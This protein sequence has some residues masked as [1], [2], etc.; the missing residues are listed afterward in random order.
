MLSR[1]GFLKSLGGSAVA[2]ALSSP[3]EVLT[4]CSSLKGATKEL[5]VQNGRD[6]YITQP[7]VAVPKELGNTLEKHISAIVG[8]G[9]ALHL[10]DYDFYHGHFL[11]DKESKFREAI[12]WENDAK[13]R[14]FTLDYYFLSV[15]AVMYHTREYLNDWIPDSNEN[16]PRSIVGLMDGSIEIPWFESEDYK[17]YGTIAGDNPFEINGKLN[18]WQEEIPLLTIGGGLYRAFTKF[19]IVP[20]KNGRFSLP[21]GQKYELYLILKEEPENN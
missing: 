10:S 2:I 14:V 7:A 21:D 13:E 9:Y 8:G 1:R 18:L 17:Q 15:R 3:L 6:I 4:S 11:F 20:N 5:R 16:V 12:D 19:Q